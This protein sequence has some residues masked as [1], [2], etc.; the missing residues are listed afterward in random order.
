[1][2]ESYGTKFDP[3]FKEMALLI[4]ENT[5]VIPLYPKSSL[6]YAAIIFQNVILDFMWKMQENEDMSIEDRKNMATYVGGEIR[7]VIFAATNIDTRELAEEI[8]DQISKE[9]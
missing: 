7:K 1:M 5:D 3:I 8:L 4:I 9:Q 6:F 2:T